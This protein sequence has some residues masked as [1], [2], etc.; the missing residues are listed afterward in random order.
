MS[1]K[2][3]IHMDVELIETHNHRRKE[4]A[5]KS[6]LRLRDDQA[7]RLVSVGRAKN[8]PQGSEPRNVDKDGNLI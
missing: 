1:E 4:Y 6:V 2:K 7:K 8:A 3:I 5:P